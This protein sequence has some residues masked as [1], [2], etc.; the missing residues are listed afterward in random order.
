MQGGVQILAGDILEGVTQQAEGD[1]AIRGE[2][3][4]G[5]IGCC[6]RSQWNR[7]VRESRS[8]VGFLHTPFRGV[9][10]LAIAWLHDD[11]TSTASR[12]VTL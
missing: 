8:A 3:P 7:S 10:T 11:T 1:V 12:D 2:W 4:V 9:H 5:N 6:L